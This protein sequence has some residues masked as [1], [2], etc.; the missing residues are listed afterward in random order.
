MH[1]MKFQIYGGRS[2][3]QRDLGAPGWNVPL[4]LVT[5]ISL[6]GHAYKQLNS[7]YLQ[8]TVFDLFESVVPKT[9]FHWRDADI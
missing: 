5:T 6:G 9:N 3:L 4:A 1:A 2:F 8:H 7:Y